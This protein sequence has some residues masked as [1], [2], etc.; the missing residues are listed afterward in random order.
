MCPLILTILVG[1]TYATL[2]LS[3][4]K[5][6][7]IFREID[8]VASN[9]PADIQ[10]LELE[11]Y[12]LIECK[13]SLKS[14]W[15]FYTRPFKFK[16]ADITG[17]YLDEIQMAARN[18]ENTE[19]METILKDAHLHYKNEER[20][21]VTADILPRYAD[22]NYNPER[23][24]IGKD[25]VCAAENV[26]K[27]YIDWSTDQ[28]IRKRSQ[29]LP[30]SIEMMFPC[31]IFQGPMYEA[32]VKNGVVELTKINHIIY[33]TL[34]RSRYSIYEKNVLIDVIADEPF[35]EEHFLEYQ[36]LISE[37]MKSLQESVRKNS[38]MI[39]RRIVETLTLLD[40]TQRRRQ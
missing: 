38:E 13:Q 9:Q 15:I 8:I 36:K 18:T 40:S 4:T 11:N 5:S 34:F 12:L 22:K 30:Y 28:D 37:N 29:I 16:N 6:P 33:K 19:I 39:S 23:D 10:N 35:G 25:A 3:T 31:I 24:E 14:A 26:L 32:I 17:H 2:T 27:K 20:V 21:A 7:T 1:K